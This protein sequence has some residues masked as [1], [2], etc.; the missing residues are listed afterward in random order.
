MHKSYS[1][2]MRRTG[3]EE[4]T[5]GERE[6]KRGQETKEDGR[7]RGRERKRTGDLRGL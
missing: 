6:G 2:R 4:R 7:E 3:G 1:Q 5:G